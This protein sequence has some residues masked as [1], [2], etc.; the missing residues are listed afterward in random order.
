MTAYYTVCFLVVSG[1]LATLGELGEESLH[2]PLPPVE[3][4]MTS[5]VTAASLRKRSVTDRWTLRAR[6]LET[7][8]Q[9]AEVRVHRSVT[10]AEC[11]DGSFMDLV[12]AFS[13]NFSPSTSACSRAV[14]VRVFH[15]LSS[16]LSCV[17]MVNRPTDD[18]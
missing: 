3:E 13:S 5:E 8:C 14:D 7:Y 6:V 16:Y 9:E 1:P 18:L 17:A 4:V 15:W 10:A 12:T 11:G 2:Q